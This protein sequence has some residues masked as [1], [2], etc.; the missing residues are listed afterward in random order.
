MRDETPMPTQRTVIVPFAELVAMRGVVDSG[1]A[2]RQ[3]ARGARRAAV[4]GRED[5]AF[6]T[7]AE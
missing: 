1:L 7:L 3:L 4:I 2:D 6:A 5:L